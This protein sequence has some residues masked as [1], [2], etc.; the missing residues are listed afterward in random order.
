M[1]HPGILLRNCDKESLTQDTMDFA[2]NAHTSERAKKR[3][4]KSR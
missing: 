2:R 3:A 4:S 1:H